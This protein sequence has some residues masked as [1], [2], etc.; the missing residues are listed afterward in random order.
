MPL[1]G[2]GIK[3]ESAPFTP[4]PQLPST[5]KPELKPQPKPPELRKMFG[6]N[7]T[8]RSYNDLRFFAQGIDNQSV[9]G[10]NGKVFKKEIGSVVSELLQRADAH[11]KV[12]GGYGQHLQP[13]EIGDV[14][15][16]HSILGKMN[17]EI[18]EAKRNNDF[19]T[20]KKLERNLK[21]AEHLRQ[22]FK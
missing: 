3:R 4:K 15:D 17:L 10:I 11:K 14:R 20:A 9:K 8:L 19:N 1:F 6:E 2:F 5:P 12:Y 22:G 13:K 7:Q 21:I 18:Q 16:K